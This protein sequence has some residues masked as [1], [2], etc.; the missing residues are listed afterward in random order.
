MYRAFGLQ[1]AIDGA[2]TG[3][4]GEVF[5]GV[6]YHRSYHKIGRGV[7]ELSVTLGVSFIRNSMLVTI[8]L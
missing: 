1:L 3:V 8:S 7:D 2:G 4:I 5:V 6:D